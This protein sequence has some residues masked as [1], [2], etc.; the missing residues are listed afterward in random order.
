MWIHEGFGQYSETVYL[1]ELYGR[2]SANKYLEGLKRGVDNKQA[3]IGPYGVNK[4]GSGDMYPKG[5]LFLNTIRNYINDDVI[6][7]DIV[8]SLQKQYRHKNISTEDV[9]ALMNEK[10][11]KNL[12]P[13]F[14][15]YLR[16]GSLPIFN[17]E[18]LERNKSVSVKYN[19]TNVVDGFAM[20]INVKVKGSNEVYTL[21]ADKN[22][23][24]IP[25]A[26]KD[27]IEIDKS[28]AYYKLD[29]K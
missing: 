8:A 3:V 10:S 24:L 9:L 11:G 5:A 20:P 4:E 26:N 15:V 22:E 21:S 1:E 23:I 14:D 29:L 6:W 28:R 17:V 27:Q 7:W 19:W 18:I 25:G 13:L 16:Q 12:K 2:E